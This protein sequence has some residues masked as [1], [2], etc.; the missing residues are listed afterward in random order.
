[1]TQLKDA[2]VEL[3]AQVCRS[4]LPPPLSGPTVIVLQPLFLRPLSHQDCDRAN[5]AANAGDVHED[6]VR[7]GAQHKYSMQASN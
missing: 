4:S 1:M 6:E 3:D 7:K 2:G 5:K